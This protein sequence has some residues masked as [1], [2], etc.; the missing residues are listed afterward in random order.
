M[1]YEVITP[2]L[3]DAVGPEGGRLVATVGAVELGT[4]DQGRITSYNVCYTKLLRG[5]EELVL[6]PGFHHLQGFFPSLDDAVG[7]E[8]GRLVA[9][10]RAVELGAVDQGAAVV[11]RDGVGRLGGGTFTLFKDAVL[12][13]ARQGLHP[14]LLAVFGQEGQAGSEVFLRRFLQS[15]FRI[16]SDNV[17]YTKLLRAIRFLS[18]PCTPGSAG[19]RSGCPAAHFCGIS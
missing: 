3:D 16:T 14:F 10:V 6:G 7:P 5:D 2:S 15:R 11:Y 17:C 1:L 8:G 18:Y 4:V 9:T 12:Q 13:S 19:S